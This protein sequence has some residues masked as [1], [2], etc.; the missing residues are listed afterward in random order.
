M[1]LLS[2]E[3]KEKS[4]GIKPL[5][6]GASLYLSRG[7]KVGVVGLNGM[8][9]STLLK[10]IAGVEQYDSGVL[11]KYLIWSFII[12]LNSLICKLEIQCCNKYF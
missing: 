4:Y 5:L 8:G 9:K 1:L 10:I 7:D 3:K 6:E 2:A 11:Q 12:C